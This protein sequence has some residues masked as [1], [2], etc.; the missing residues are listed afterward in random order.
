MSLFKDAFN[1]I[2][3]DLSFL[4]QNTEKTIINSDLSHVDYSNFKGRLSSI[5]FIFNLVKAVDEWLDQNPDASSI[6]PS[7]IR[8]QEQNSD[9]NQPNQ[10]HTIAI[11]QSVGA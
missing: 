9:Q 6:P 5:G 10:V 1:T 2:K 3:N 4:A 11:D 7:F 8:S